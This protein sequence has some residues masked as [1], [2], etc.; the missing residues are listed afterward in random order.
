MEQSQNPKTNTTAHTTNTTQWANATKEPYTNV[1][2]LQTPNPARQGEK[3]PSV[4]V[5]KPTIAMLAH[6][7]SNTLVHLHII[8]KIT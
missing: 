3:K 7:S 8:F 4:T 2:Y 6:V 5:A 1:Q